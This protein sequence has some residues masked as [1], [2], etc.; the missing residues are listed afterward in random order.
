MRY[1]KRIDTE[2]LITTVESYS[3]E[4]DIDGAIEITEQEFNG[5]LS[6]SPVIEPQPPKSTHLATLVSVTI[7]TRPAR[8]KRIWQGRDYFFD[9]YVTQTVKDEYTSGKIA[10]GDY[11]IVHFDNEMNEQIV[12]AKVYKSW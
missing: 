7:D 2:G 9:C 8:V 3:H 6:S 12:T 5:Y 10:I 4:L 11:V 1:W